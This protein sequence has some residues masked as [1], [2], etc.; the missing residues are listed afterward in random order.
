[1]LSKIPVM[2]SAL[3]IRVLFVLASLRRAGAE[4]QMVSFING[5]SRSVIQPHLFTYLPNLA[6]LPQ[7]DTNGLTLHHYPRQHKL[8]GT[9][10]SRLA[11]IIDREQ[12]DLVHC[13]LEHALFVGWTGRALAS[14]KPPLVAAL[15]TTVNNN[16]KNEL[17]NR[18]LYQWLLRRCSKTIFV[19]HR[20]RDYWIKTYRIPP[21]RSVVI[22]NGINTDRFSTSPAEPFSPSL[23]SELNLSA[24]TK[25]ICCIANFRPEKAHH[26]LIRAFSLLDPNFHLILAG[27]GP[28]K[29]LI[30]NLVSELRL[31][32]RVSFLGEVS[33]PRPVLEASDLSVLSSVA[34]ETFS[35]AML[36]SMSMGV[37]V[38]ASDIG[39]LSE[40]IFSGYNGYLVPPG[41]PDALAQAIN[42]IFADPINLG[43]MKE[44]CRELVVERFTE[45]EM[46]RKT[47][48]VLLEAFNNYSDSPLSKKAFL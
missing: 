26:V 10:Y 32:N 14:R 17:A 5:L 47:E 44:R 18:L 11:K 48:H 25:V 24:D 29:P 13:T 35:M 36:E 30:E 1:M 23:R 31:Q 8:D 46:V 22:P 27:D 37:P 4:T 34:V 43:R 2:Q 7:L 6:L 3:P 40:A 9:T 16:R 39:G 21:E 33:D 42:Q 19:S 38:V 45:A 20:Q 15:H 12:I 41:Q 28:T